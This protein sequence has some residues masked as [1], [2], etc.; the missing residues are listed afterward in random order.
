MNSSIF[1]G[2]MKVETVPVSLKKVNS[3]K[4]VYV[5]SHQIWPKHTSDSPELKQPPS[6][7]IYK[8]L[9]F[10]A[11]ALNIKSQNKINE[12]DK[13]NY[14]GV[15]LGIYLIFI[16]SRPRGAAIIGWRE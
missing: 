10:I 15:D 4:S 5:K 3:T 14:K 8:D 1:G 9:G 6:K 13:Y 11:H 12:M 2:Q 16:R 7:E